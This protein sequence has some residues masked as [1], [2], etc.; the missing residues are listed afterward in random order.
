MEVS[1]GTHSVPTILTE[2][3]KRLGITLTD[4]HV[5]RFA[6]FQEILLDWN[7][8]INLTAITDPTDVQVRHFLDS[9]TV[10][11]ALPEP[12]R[13]GQQTARLIDVG[14]GAGL[15]GI[16]LAIVQ[17]NLSVVLLEATQKKCRFLEHVIADL[18]LSNARVVCGRAEEIAHLPE[19][20]ASYDF[21]VARA[22]ASLA[23][24]A[25]LCLPLARTGGE[26]VALKKLGVEDELR[27][28]TKAIS[29]LGGKLLAPVIVTVPVIEEDRQLVRI[30]KVRPSPA[31]YPRRPG[32]PAKS[33][34]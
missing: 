25:E 30:A 20:R 17:E 1:A 21:V 6:R 34:L 9:L 32:V 10:L 7:Q 27:S 28:S 31:Q 18:K 24:L 15:P 4:V 22:V 2:G 23:T 19:H 13:T 33:P 29:T 5:D 3:A 26:V 11:R 16:P 8:R 12:V 14:T